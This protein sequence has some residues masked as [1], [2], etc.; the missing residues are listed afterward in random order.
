MKGV[1]NQNKQG[2]LFKSFL[3][4]G[5]L[6]KMLGKKSIDDTLVWEEYMN[7]TVLLYNNLVLNQS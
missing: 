5:W 2:K 7:T 4:M 1:W 6:V 3:D